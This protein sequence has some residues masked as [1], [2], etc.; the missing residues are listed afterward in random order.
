MLKLDEWVFFLRSF[1]VIIGDSVKVV[2]FENVI[3]VVMV[4]V[5]LVNKWLIFFLRKIKGIN[6][7]ISMSVVVII[8][9]FIFFVLW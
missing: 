6:I 8:V 3:V 2:K 1:D 4:R 9:N 7:E 5:N